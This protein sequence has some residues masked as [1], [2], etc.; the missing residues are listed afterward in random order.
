VICDG[1]SLQT[2]ITGEHVETNDGLPTMDCYDMTLQD[3]KT[4]N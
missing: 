2:S 4:T 1:L 3:A